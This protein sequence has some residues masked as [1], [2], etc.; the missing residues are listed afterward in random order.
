MLSTC[1]DTAAFWTETRWRLY[2]RHIIQMDVSPSELQVVPRLAVEAPT[3]LNI[4]HMV[5]PGWRWR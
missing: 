1:A 3:T 2:M 5:G 4:N